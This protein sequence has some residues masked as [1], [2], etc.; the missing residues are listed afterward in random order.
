MLGEEGTES[1]RNESEGE[2]EETG[3]SKAFLVEDDRCPL[4]IG[5]DDSVVSSSWATLEGVDS[6]LLPI[7]IATSEGTSETSGLDV[8]GEI[9]FL[10][11]FNCGK[12]VRKEAV[13][14]KLFLLLIGSE[15]CICKETHQ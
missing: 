2:R 5:V 7:L 9:S 14:S 10:T 8:V 15:R 1:L 4:A 13:R 12:R 11:R 3:A 6:T